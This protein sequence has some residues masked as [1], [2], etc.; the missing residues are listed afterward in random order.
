MHCQVMLA[1]S[2]KSRRYRCGNRADAF[3]VLVFALFSVTHP[4]FHKALAER[5][6]AIPPTDRLILACSDLHR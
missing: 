4:Q 2:S 3:S 5:V 6:S 1:R